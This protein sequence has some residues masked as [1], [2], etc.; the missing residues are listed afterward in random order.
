MIRNSIVL[1]ITLYYQ[2]KVSRMNLY[3]SR[4]LDADNRDTTKVA[5]ADFESMLVSVIPYKAFTRFLGTEKP[6]MIP[7]LRIVHIYKLYQ[8]DQEEL[9]QLKQ[10]LNSSHYTN[11]TMKS[12]SRKETTLE[13]ERL[14]EL[15]E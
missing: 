14:R 1:F 10:D 7:Y 15:M 9:G 11:S 12:M 4:L 13:V 8:D 2:I 5:L 3:Y 6:Q